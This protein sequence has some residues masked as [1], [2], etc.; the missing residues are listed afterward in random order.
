MLVVGFG[1]DALRAQG[2][3]GDLNSQVSQLST[4]L[5]SAESAN[6]EFKGIVETQ[7]E[8]ESD[9]EGLVEDLRDRSEQ[10][11]TELRARAP[12]PNLVGKELSQARAQVIGRGWT[13]RIIKEPST[14][15]EGTILAQSP[16]PGTQMKLRK[17]VTLT[18]AKPIPAPPA[19]P[20]AQQNC[21][22]S[23]EG[24]CLDPNA[25]DYDCIGGSGDGP[26]F[27]G[28]VRVVGP[29]VFGLDGDGDGIGCE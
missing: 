28:T 12:L 20:P 26:L 4:E 10:A 15:P 13:L 22:P 24:A 25:S 6:Q 1:A 3:I 11:R 29:D 2:R 14:E 18:I 5:S 23:Y 7:T 16:H 8:R 19:P 9:L 21:H 27:T 17:V